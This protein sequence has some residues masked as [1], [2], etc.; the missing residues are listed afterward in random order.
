MLKKVLAGLSA[1]SL[2]LGV[3][4]L[5]VVGPAG[6]ARADT[7]PDST[8]T[9]TTTSGT[10]G[11]DTSTPSD[12]PA[13]TTPPDTTPSDPPADPSDPPVDPSSEGSQSQSFVQLDLPTDPAPY[14]IVA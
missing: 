5:T 11:T 2:G 8:T 6:A 14:L 3:I 12:P 7:T 4:A 9:T 10:P 1:V 13:D